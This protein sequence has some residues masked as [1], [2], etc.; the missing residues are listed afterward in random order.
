MYTHTHTNKG[1]P[2]APG[3]PLCVLLPHGLMTTTSLIN[4]IM[5]IVAD[6]KRGGAR[7]ARGRPANKRS[8]ILHS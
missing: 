7:G 6:N 2:A 8:V 5:Y 4:T 3:H 1:N